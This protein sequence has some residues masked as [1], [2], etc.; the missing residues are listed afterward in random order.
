M[1]QIHAEA[2][3]IIDARPEEIY[4]ILSDYHEGH[5]AILPKAYFAE[6]TVEKGGKGAGTIIRVGMN[7]MGVK[8]TYRMV[9]SEPE[10]G[11]V[12]VEADEEAGVVTT[13]TIDPSG[14]Q[15]RV[16]ISTNAKA[17]PG[18]MGWLERLVNPPITR[19]IFKKQFRLLVDYVR[20][21]HN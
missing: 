3:A 6:L 11:R 17:S 14:N 15:S 12:L 5:P 19:H 9:V 2:S 10:P 20:S 13:F 7:V 1:S 4:A 21:K 16:T 8:R 18:L